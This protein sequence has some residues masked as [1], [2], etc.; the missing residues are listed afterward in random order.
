MYGEAVPLRA[1]MTIPGL[2]KQDCTELLSELSVREIAL[3]PAV[4]L[5]RI[6]GQGKAEAI[7]TFFQSDYLTTA[8]TEVSKYL[9]H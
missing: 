9:Y 6:V 3:T 2:T 8:S 5:Q 7:E 1:L 4:S